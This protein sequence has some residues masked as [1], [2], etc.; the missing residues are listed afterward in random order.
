MILDGKTLRYYP[1]QLT[2]TA[3]TPNKSG[4]CFFISRHKSEIICSISNNVQRLHQFMQNWIKLNFC[5]SSKR[6]FHFLEGYTFWCKCS[7]WRGTQNHVIRPPSKESSWLWS[8]YPPLSVWFGKCS[9][10][11]FL[12]ICSLMLLQMLTVIFCNMTGCWF[13]HVGFGH[14]W[15]SFLNT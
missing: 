10:W 1:F 4:Y 2:P 6:D 11:Q 13:D 9:C 3:V 8:K 12:L 5:K 7:W 15:S 14:P